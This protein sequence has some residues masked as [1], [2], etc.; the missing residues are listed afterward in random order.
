MTETIIHVLLITGI[1]L[2]GGV[3]F[4]ALLPESPN[5]K[6]AS[7]GI[8]SAASLLT[9]A[10]FLGYLILAGQKLGWW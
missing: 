5:K 6:E 3:F 8:K 10:I 4:A 2:V 1:V 9:G 7:R